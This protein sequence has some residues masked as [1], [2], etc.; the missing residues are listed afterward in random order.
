MSRK[1]PWIGGESGRESAEVVIV[2]IIYQASAAAGVEI[3]RVAERI[4]AALEG[5]AAV[6]GGG[7]Q[8]SASFLEFAQQFGEAVAV[9][10]GWL[11]SE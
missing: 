5:A 3:E 6:S 9:G 8:Y 4:V 2:M 10:G 1:I 7:T 11:G